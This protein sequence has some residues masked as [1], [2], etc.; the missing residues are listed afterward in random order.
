M[1]VKVKFTPEHAVE[2][3][4]LLRYIL[5]NVGAK[6]VWAQHVGTYNKLLPHTVIM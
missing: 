5:F 1:L 4:R 3:I 2:E 6:W